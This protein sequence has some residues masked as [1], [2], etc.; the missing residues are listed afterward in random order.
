MACEWYD[1]PIFDE[2]HEQVGDV[3]LRGDAWRRLQAIK[4]E[5]TPTRIIKAVGTTFRSAEIVAVMREGVETVELVAEPTNAH[6]P[7]AVKVLLN[8]RHVGYLARGSSVV[9]TLRVVSV[10]VS[11]VA[12]VWVAV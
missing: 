3:V 4:V 11:P 6:D 12:H 7:N 5:I 2:A 10:G 9:G 1:D 8:S